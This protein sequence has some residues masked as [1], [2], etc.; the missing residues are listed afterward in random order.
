M[1]PARTVRE[2]LNEAASKL[3]AAEV[4]LPA[5]EAQ[6]LMAH[7]LGTSRLHV[8]TRMDE[9][10]PSSAWSQL[11]ALVA[12]RSVR[13]P[14][15]Y[16]RGVQEFYGLE[17]VV[18]PAVLIPRPET[19]LLVDLVVETLKDSQEATLMD[20]GTGSGCVAVTA[21]VRLPHLRVVG[22]DLCGD[23]IAVAGENARRLG[24]ADRVNLLCTDFRTCALT[25]GVDM[26]VSNPPYIPTDELETLQ[27]EVRVFE[28]RVA[29]DGGEDGFV[30]HRALVPMAGRQLKPTSALAVEVG[31]GQAPAVARLMQDAGFRQIESRRDL[32]G[33]ERVVLGRLGT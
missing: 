23:A 22:I 16:I 11:D 8:L 24:V 17:F 1:Q 21:A 13:E 4:E 28:P 9:P 33:I 20:V 26:I 14:T 30:F 7:T 29:L 31:S 5:F 27:A 3:S 10:L 18:S 19:E 15:A 12:R 32:Q 2:G 6:L 25:Y